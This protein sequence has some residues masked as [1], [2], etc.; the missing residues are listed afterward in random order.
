MLVDRLL[1][2]GP[3]AG[4][5]LFQFL[6]GWGSK[7]GGR[8]AKIQEKVD[9]SESFVKTGWSGTLNEPVA[10]GGVE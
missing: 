10:I 9:R 8:V 2:K 5:S 6:C 4:A 1:C 3:E 7:P